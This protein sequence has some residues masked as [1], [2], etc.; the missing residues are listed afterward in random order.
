MVPAWVDW[1]VEWVRVEV[2]L[3]RLLIVIV[4]HVVPR[5]RIH[6]SIGIALVL[7]E[8]I[9]PLVLVLVWV[10]AFVPPGHECISDT[11]HFIKKLPRRV[12]GNKGSRWRWRGKLGDLFLLLVGIHLWEGINESSS[13]LSIQTLFKLFSTNFSRIGEI[14]CFTDQLGNM[15]VQLGIKHSALRE[16]P[17]E[18]T[19]RVI[20]PDDLFELPL[21]FLLV[22]ILAVQ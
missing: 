21:I 19:D 20:V 12:L 8:L 7:V 11:E 14:F 9:V 5:I 15:F 1:A 16:F 6:E 4:V 22:L 13:T 2:K 18:L 3:L 10:S 17:K